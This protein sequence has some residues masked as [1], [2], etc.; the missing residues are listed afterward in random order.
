MALQPQVLVSG[1][2]RLNLASVQSRIRNAEAGVPEGGRVEL[3]L[4]FP[5]GG[6]PYARIAATYL[7]EAAAAGLLNV[8][9]ESIR[10]WPEQYELA[11][12][13]EATGV[14]HI[15]WLKGVEFSPRVILTLIGIGLVGGVLIYL[16]VRLWR[17]IYWFV[18]EVVAPVITA[19]TS[20]GPDITRLLILGGIVFAGV[21]LLR[22]LRGP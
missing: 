18:E 17:L 20:G 2:D 5:T 16:A 21:F 11:T 19:I 6:I 13:D 3:Q 12:F 14:T 7:N 10:T 15:R 1:S 8:A 22:Q 4:H 9:N